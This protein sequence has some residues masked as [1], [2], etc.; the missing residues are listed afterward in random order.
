[1]NRGVVVSG[2]EL[3]GGQWERSEVGDLLDQVHGGVVGLL[4]ARAGMILEMRS[5][6]SKGDKGDGPALCQKYTHIHSERFE[7]EGR[8][9][10]VED[11]EEDR[12]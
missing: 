3:T 11:D 10:G 4:K 8:S 9:G 5:G 12:R 7:W 1:M 2:S 6:K